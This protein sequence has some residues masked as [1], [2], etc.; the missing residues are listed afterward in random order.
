MTVFEKHFSP[1][2]AS[3]GGWKRW[4]DCGL[5][6]LAFAFLGWL[7]MS[8][9]AETLLNV[10]YDPTREFYKEFNSEDRQ[11]CHHQDVPWRFR[12]TG[13]RRH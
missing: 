10:S 9:R 2:S 12:Q 8:A 1:K 4:R 13:T 7:T 5:A 6:L 11:G 3:F